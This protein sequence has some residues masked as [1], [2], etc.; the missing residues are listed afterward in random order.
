MT[1]HGF[2]WEGQ[3]VAITSKREGARANLTDRGEET[4]R[5]EV[6]ADGSAVATFVMTIV[7]EE[8]EAW[9]LL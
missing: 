9:S 1:A 2:A 8:K 7:I 6:S 4:W 3:F 5:C